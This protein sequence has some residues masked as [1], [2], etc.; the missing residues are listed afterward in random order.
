MENIGA[1]LKV[2]NTIAPEHSKNT[3]IFVENY[4]S[5]DFNSNLKNQKVERIKSFQ[6]FHQKLINSQIKTN[7]D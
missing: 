7:F 1:N 6:T 4:E 5:D 2:E 3:K